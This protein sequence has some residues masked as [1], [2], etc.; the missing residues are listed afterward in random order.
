MFDCM[1]Q[2]DFDGEDAM[3]YRVVR[4]VAAV[5]SDFKPLC[6]STDYDDFLLSRKLP[7]DLIHCFRQAQTPS[8]MEES[9]KK[10]MN[11]MK[12]K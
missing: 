4:E 11:T 7:A 1:I 10:M 8:E 6:S 5:L 2:E 12:G 9:F 3:Y